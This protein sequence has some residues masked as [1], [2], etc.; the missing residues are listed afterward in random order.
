[1]INIAYRG[2]SRSKYLKYIYFILIC[3]FFCLSYISITFYSISFNEILLEKLSRIGFSLLTASF[4]LFIIEITN[5]INKKSFLNILII[6][7]GTILALITGIQYSKEGIRY[8]FDI[9]VFGYIIPLFILNTVL[10]LISIIRDKNKT[11]L[12]IFIAFIQ[13]IILSIHDILV[14]SIFVYI[15]YAWLTPYGYIVLV[16]A[17]YIILSIEHSIVYKKLVERNKVIKFSLSLAKNVQ[18]HFV[19][20]ID[21]KIKD[22]Q[23]YTYYK[24]MDDVSGDFYELIELSDDELGIFISDVSG[25]GVGSGIVTSMLKILCQSTEKSIS[26]PSKFLK[27]INMNLIGIIGNNHVT[28]F[29]GI[30]DYKSNEFI[31]SNASHCYP[32]LYRK[33]NGKIIKLKSTGGMIGISKKIDYTTRRIEIKKGDVLLFFTDGLIDTMN[34]KGDL[35][36]YENIYQVLKDFKHT[37]INNMV[38]E[39]LKSC[40]NFSDNKKLDDDITIVCIEIL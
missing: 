3:I 32:I 22:Y 17:L 16:L 14:L 25:H 9:I 18:K 2:Y 1:M 34:K 6:T 4:S 8:I 26:N 39:L 11:T 36:D 28:A 31:Y 5:I 38:N 10:L 27:Y 15:P 21:R 7:L 30:I 29:Y 35:F 33:P 37:S 12:F 20:K 13:I 40:Y 23:V 24:P 19:K